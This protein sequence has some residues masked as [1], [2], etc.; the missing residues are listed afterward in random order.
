MKAIR[1]HEFG[2]PEVMKLEEVP[3]PKPG[4]GQVLVRVKAAGVN[5]VD[6][7]IRAGISYRKPDM[8]WTPGYDAGGIVEA[9]GGGVKGFKAGDRIYTARTISGAYAELVLCE[10]NQVHPLPAN[11]SFAQ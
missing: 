2:G 1:V 4:P 6:T 11:V 3:D 5:P 8:P 9:V 7:Y 10:E